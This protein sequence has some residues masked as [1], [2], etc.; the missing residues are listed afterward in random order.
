MSVIF[1]RPSALIGDASENNE[2]VWNAVGNPIIYSWQYY[3]GIV[4]SV[5]NGGGD[6]FL[7]ISGDVSAQFGGTTA[8]VNAP[9]YVGVYIV[10]AA[11]FALGI[12]TVELATPFISDASGYAFGVDNID[13]GFSVEIEI[14]DSIT[15]AQLGTTLTIAA[16]TDGLIKSSDIS[17][18]IKAY[19]SAEIDVDLTGVDDYFD[20]VNGYRSTYVI[21]TLTI[22]GVDQS[23]VNDSANPIYSVFGAR[24]IPSPYGGNMG[25][26]VTFADGDP[27]AKFLTIFTRPKMWRSFP[28]IISVIN[29]D[30]TTGDC[31]LNVRYNDSEGNLIDEENSAPN[32]SSVGLYIFN[33]INILAIPDNAVTCDLTLFRV[34][35]ATELTETLTCDI[36]SPCDNPIMLVARNSLGGVLQ[37]VFDAS[38][39][40]LPDYGNDIKSFRNVLY[41]ENLSINEYFALQ[42]FIRLGDIYR[43]NIIE[44]TAD[45][46]KTASRIGH[47]VY[48]VNVEGEKIGVI[49]IP[50]RNRTETKQKKHRFELEIEY[51][52]EFTP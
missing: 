29:A 25:G 28:F 13:T 18:L 20:D 40:H 39:D 5:I 37:W 33:V 24:Q 44:F 31:F 46:I 42:D 12:T 49:A 35:G 3:D 27:K 11:P 17:E 22:D 41:A 36:A 7:Q 48:I 38:Q 19:L 16:G 45:T 6:A 34:T 4:D 9:P 8:Y 21:Y 43:D 52:E 51:P 50:T 10:S 2:S 14:R 32:I 26:Y 47:Q 1:T 23:P 15:S 30:S